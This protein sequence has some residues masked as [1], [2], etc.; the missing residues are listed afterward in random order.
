M[1][2]ALLRVSF[3]NGDVLSTTFEGGPTATGNRSS[4]PFAAVTVPEPGTFLLAALAAV[5]LS[6]PRRQGRESHGNR[7]FRTRAPAA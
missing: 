3:A 2:H 1:N 4:F 7:R 5:C 6:L